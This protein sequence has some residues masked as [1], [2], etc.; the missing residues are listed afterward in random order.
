MS[1]LTLAQA[2]SYLKIASV[3]AARDTELQA[4]IDSAEATLVDH[5]GPLT[6]TSKTVRILLRSPND[7]L[8]LPVLPALSLTSVTG[9]LSGNTIDVDELHLESECGLVTYADGVR[10]F[11]ESQDVVY[12]AGY[13][14]LPADLLNGIKELVRHRWEPQRG[15]AG[16]PGTGA[17]RADEP[18]A[19][20][21]PASV[22]ALIEQYA[23]ELGFA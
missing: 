12:A 11:V 4:A 7:T 21:M 18:D 6:S 20:G 15:G 16:K 8:I 17:D 14:P 13:S 1:A 22:V 10:L 9:V 3:D 2:K 19:D 5:V 23:D